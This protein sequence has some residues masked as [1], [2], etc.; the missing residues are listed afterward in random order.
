MS[1]FQPL[2]VWDRGNETQP[3][4][5]ENLNNFTQLSYQGKI[6]KKPRKTRI[7]QTPPTHPLVNFLRKHVQNIP[8]KKHTKNP[9]WVLT[10]P[11]TSYLF[12]IYLF[13]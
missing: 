4:V 2:E 10:N 1:N 11:P 13:I 7:G 9:S 5:V 8:E 3:Q 6:I 12:Y